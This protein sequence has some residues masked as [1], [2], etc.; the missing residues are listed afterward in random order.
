MSG[1][2]KRRRPEG[3]T[4]TSGLHGCGADLRSGKTDIGRRRASLSRF[5]AE[6]RKGE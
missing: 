2:K 1:G 4:A 3:R 5:A 6:G